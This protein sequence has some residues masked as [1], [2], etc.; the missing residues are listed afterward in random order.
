[1]SKVE[2]KQ[3]VAIYCR[4]SEEDKD[5]KSKADDS[6]SI[7]NQKIMLE[8]YAL[9][10]GWEI[11]EIYS[12][13]NYSGADRNRP[14]FNRMLK[15]AENHKFDI[16]ICKTSSRFTRESEVF[17]E[18]IEKKFLEWGIR[19]LG[20]LN[21]VDNHDKKGKKIR[22]VNALVDEWYLDDISMNIKGVLTEKREKGIHIGSFA[23]YGYK[24]D[25]NEKGHLIIDE[26]AAQVVREVFNL[27]CSGYGKTKIA[28]TLNERGI[29]NP[30]EYKRIHGLR[31]KQP[32]KKNS[33]LWK[34]FSI[35]DMLHNEMYIGNM[36]QGKYGS[37]S[38]KTKKNKPRPKDE[39]YRV[40]GTHEPII[41]RETWDRVQAL[42]AQKSKPFKGGEIGL[43]AHK[44]RCMNCDY[45]MASNKQSDG[46]RYLMCSNRHVHKDA[47]IGSFISIAKLEQAVIE[48]LNK[49]SMVYLIKD[50]LEQKVE[51]SNKLTKEKD[52]LK[53]EIVTY[54]KKVEEYNTAIREA[55]LDKVKKIITEQDYLDLSRNFSNEKKMCEKLIADK[56]K[57]L[58]NIEEKIKA[59]KN[60]RQLIEQYTNIEHLDRMT[61]ETLIDFIRV[62]KKDPITKEVPIEIHWNF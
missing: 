54:Q 37:V 24:K 14:A 17:N 18:F 61:V 39:W 49:L 30:T 6:E 62:G 42:L 51:F 5:K 46:R 16:V 9:E 26:E 34:Y 50:E 55:Y 33:T 2:K 4:L 20:I 41:D 28:C 15:D 21:N 47:C 60:K 40:E 32:A 48:E 52:I 7:Q 12:D 35:S 36:V 29:P 19:F 23:L 44:V 8:K 10:Q 1:M 53:K 59:G 3:R 11:Y 31:Y 13:D 43:F 38:Y 25:P 27:F 57:E 22:Q 56:Q 58:Q 45:T